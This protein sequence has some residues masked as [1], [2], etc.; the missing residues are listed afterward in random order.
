MFQFLYIEHCSKHA[1][2]RFTSSEVALQDFLG[3][4]GSNLAS[5]IGCDPVAR[6]WFWSLRNDYRRA[7]K[8]SQQQLMSSVG[9]CFETTRVSVAVSKA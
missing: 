7:L 3:T 5:S 2:A 4:A 9:P 6:M 8:A 1:L